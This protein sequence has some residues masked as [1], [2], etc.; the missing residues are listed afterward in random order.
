LT[1]VSSWV[2]ETGLGTVNL[3]FSESKAGSCLTADHSVPMRRMRLHKDSGVRV[4]SAVR[5]DT[6]VVRHRVEEM[7][8]A[9]H[10]PES[11]DPHE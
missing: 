11:I 1:H 10:E 5:A 6:R 2:V 8:L 9:L 3:Q 4:A 7:D